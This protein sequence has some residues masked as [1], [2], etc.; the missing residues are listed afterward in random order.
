MEPLSTSDK[1]QPV[2]IRPGEGFAGIKPIT[3]I[4]AFDDVVAKFGN[5]P[6]LHQKVLS[7]VS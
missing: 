1:T 6:A 7:S 3:Q 4:Q 5:K 2:Q